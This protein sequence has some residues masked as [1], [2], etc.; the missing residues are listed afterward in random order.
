MNDAFI[1]E[2]LEERYRLDALLG[3]GGYGEVYEAEQIRVRRRVAVKIL[4]PG[5]DG[6]GTVVKR[7]EREAQF[8]SRLD[9]PHIVSVIDYGRAPAHDVLYL[10][11]E[12]VE[13]RDVDSMLVGQQPLALDVTL[14]IVGQVAEALQHAH[15]RGVIHRDIKPH[16]IMVTERNGDP[17]WVKVIDFGIGRA[18]EDPSVDTMT[19]L[20]DS[21]T[22]IGTPHYMAP[23]QIEDGVIDGRADQYAL[24]MTITKMLSGRTMYRG[25]AVDVAVAQLSRPRLSIHDLNPSVRV[26]PAFQEALFRAMERRPGARF[27][28]ISAFAEA[29]RAGAEVAAARPA[30][31]VSTQPLDA[32]VI[33]EIEQDVRREHTP[34]IEQAGGLNL[35]RI[36]MPTPA[37]DASEVARRMA[38][39]E[40]Q[41]DA[42]TESPALSVDLQPPVASSAAVAEAPREILGVAPWA[43]YVLVCSAL[44]LLASVIAVVVLKG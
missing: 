18:L 22:M 43:I 19:A 16:N 17:W 32:S 3:R 36:T 13:G 42:L 12:Y 24:A 20:T 34:P 31:N 15:D 44:F 11:M 5:R 35:Q 33:A 2:V 8:T 14:K 37:V 7:F 6:I 29:L 25:E 10:V 27:P 4:R 30:L 26:P 21:G 40:V 39:H 1:G 28:S 41:Q 23:E 9:H 38:E